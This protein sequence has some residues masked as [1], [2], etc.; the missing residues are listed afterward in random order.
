MAIA[1]IEHLDKSINEIE[2]VNTIELWVNIRA[3]EF[4][5]YFLSEEV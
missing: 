4:L 1:K 2:I 5:E 3:D